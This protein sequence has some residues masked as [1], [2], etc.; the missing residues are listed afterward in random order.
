MSTSAAFTL[1]LVRRLV[2]F[3]QANTNKSPN[4]LS[5]LPLLKR[6]L[7]NCVEVKLLLEGIVDATKCL[8]V[9]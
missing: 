6:G 7:S 4:T 5:K 8:A 3:V 2:R 9:K 1:H